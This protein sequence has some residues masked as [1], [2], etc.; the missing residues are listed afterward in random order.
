MW[1]Q[2]NTTDSDKA[3]ALAKAFFDLLRLNIEA[4]NLPFNYGGEQEDHNLIKQDIR[5]KETE[6][7]DRF[8]LATG[9]TLYRVGP[10]LF[11]D[12]VKV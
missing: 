2:R 9:K 3:E 6:V 7:F 4:G 5:Q 12:G 11:V 8:K 10:E 1:N